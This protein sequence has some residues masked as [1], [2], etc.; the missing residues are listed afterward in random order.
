[1]KTIYV[2]DRY[3]SKYIK[4]TGVEEVDF[5]ALKPGDMVVYHMDNWETNSLSIAT[6][7][8]YEVDTDRT[9]LFERALLWKE[10]EYFDEQQ[11]YADTFFSFFKKSFKERFKNS[12]PV[13]ARYHI[14]AHQVYFYFYAEERY[15][16]GDYVRTLREKVWKNIFLFQVGARDMVRISPSAKYFLTVDGRPLHSSMSWPL[17]SVPMDN[18]M[19]Q[20]LDGRD[21]ERLKGRSGKLKESIM[22]E[23]ALYEEEAKKFPARWS[24][25]ETKTTGVKGVCLS[26][27]I[28]NANVTI[29]TKDSEIYRLPLEQLHV[30]NYW[31]R[32]EPRFRKRNEK[33]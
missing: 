7:L 19:L 4:V 18:I 1:M 15:V 16:F 9:G 27:N 20:H 8:W 11:E 23:S 33:L 21:V 29:K 28:M 25:V 10:K 17:P 3:V 26:F 24:S 32:E 5:K 31:K 14:F 13:A 2:L 22:Y 6:F 12:K 30:K